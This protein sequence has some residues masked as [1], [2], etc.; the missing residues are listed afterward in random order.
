MTTTPPCSVSSDG[1][2]RAD[3]DLD[4][5]SWRC[6]CGD[7]GAI[8]P[9]PDTLS[10]LKDRLARGASVHLEWVGTRQDNVES[11]IP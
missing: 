10:L 7:E 1:V 6:G 4:D 5:Q 3:V 11:S 8:H 2:H 9:D